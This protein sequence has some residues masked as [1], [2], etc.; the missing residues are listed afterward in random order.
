MNICSL[1][2]FYTTLV[3]YC[4]VYSSLFAVFID[5][6]TF[7]SFFMVEITDWRFKRW[8]SLFRWCG[9]F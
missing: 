2:S 1:I 7:I 8:I 6:F 3:S 9:Y 5:H 4:K